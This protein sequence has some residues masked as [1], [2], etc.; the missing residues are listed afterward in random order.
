MCELK[1][2]IGCVHVCIHMNFELNELIRTAGADFGWFLCTAIC[3][4]TQDS[5]ETLNVVIFRVFGDL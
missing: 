1:H 5:L 3:K 4:H 2:I